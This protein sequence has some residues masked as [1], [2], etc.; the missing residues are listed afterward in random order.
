MSGCS[1][2]GKQDNCQ[3]A[4]SLSVANDVA[5]LPIAYRL[6]LPQIWADDPERRGRAKVPAEI[7]F[8]T[9]PQIGCCQTN[10]NSSPV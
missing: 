2:L 9:K 4:V 7:A 10:G 6:D 5:N 1:Q 8:Q 3:V